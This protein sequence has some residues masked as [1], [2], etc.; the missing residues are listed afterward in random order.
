MSRQWYQDAVFYEIFVRSFYDSNGDGW[1][2]LPGIT[3]KLDYLQWLGVDC[4]WLLPFFDS[5]LKDGGY[6]V[7]DFYA[8]HPKYGTLEDFKI[9]IKEAHAR[10]IKVIGDLVLNH[11]SDENAWFQ[12]ARDPSSPRHDWYVWSN[13]T[14]KYTDARI[15]FSD[16]EDSNWQWDD[17]AG[18]YYWHRFFR[19][20]PDLNYDNPEVQAE[21]ISVAKYWLELGLD[22]F[23]L[24][25]VPH[26]YEREGTN[27]ESLPE[28]H[29]FLQKLRA[30]VDEIKPGAVLL[31]ET[32][33]TP[34]KL[35]PYFN[36]GDECNMAFN[37]PVMVDIF[38]ALRK[39]DGADLLKA[40]AQTPELP[41]GCQWGLFLRSHD[42][43]SPK[44][45][46]PDG[47]HDAFLDYYAS[48]PGARFKSGLRRRLAPMF[49]FSPEKLKLAYMLLL[50]LPGTP[51]LY[52]GDEL[53]MGD[54][55]SLGDR[56]PVR[57]P[58]P[59]DESRNAGFT[60]ADTSA[61][62]LPLA[63]GKGGWQE[64][65][66]ASAQAHEASLLVW[67][68]NMLKVRS[69]VS[70]LRSGSFRIVEHSTRGLMWYRRESNGESVEIAINLGREPVSVQLPEQQ[71][72]LS[73]SGREGGML[74]QYGYVI[75]KV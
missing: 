14:D 28:T 16:Y 68:K 15:I 46:L 47:E 33:Q 5:P 22:G 26:L 61:L 40:V 56:D 63:E 74:A 36:T 44:H 19:F 17:K 50:T 49:D 41:S 6:D 38:N 9:L 60:H 70:S 45:H 3:A 30:E 51:V 57:T 29:A 21:M 10:D 64:V 7:R 11:T 66:V 65:N 73:Q 23:R 59:W 1:G 20:Q 52:Y 25:A 2:D 35:L 75:Y 54:D 12:E 39:A 62:P 53:G 27:C 18:K 48:E 58:M 37:F 55:L 72:I 4:I 42:E 24:D 34:Q 8:I 32:N 69:S 13:T 43:L 67:L 31:A 71:T